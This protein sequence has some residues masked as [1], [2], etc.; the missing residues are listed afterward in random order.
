MGYLFLNLERDSLYW[1]LLDSLHQIGG[2][3]SNLVS[4]S[5]GRNLCVLGQDL[6]VYVEVEGELQ[7]VSLDQL[8]G[9]SLDSLSSDSSLHD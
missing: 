9:G 4:E 6:L 3:T 5:L 8:S 2:V 7:I 1:T